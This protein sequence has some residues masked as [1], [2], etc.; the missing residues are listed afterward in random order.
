M[1]LSA[2]HILKRTLFTRAIKSHFYEQFAKYDD[3]DGDDDDR[4]AAACLCRITITLIMKNNSIIGMIIIII[5]VLWNIVVFHFF[6]AALI[7]NLRAAFTIETSKNI[8][9]PL[10]KQPRPPPTDCNGTLST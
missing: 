1:R 9:S 2:G 6:A 3:D 8:T 10:D 4:Q 7:V 5:I